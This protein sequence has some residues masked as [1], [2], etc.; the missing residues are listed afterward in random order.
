MEE[1]S[2]EEKVWVQKSQC[3]GF[4]FL[5][6]KFFEILKILKIKII[7]YLNKFYSFIDKTIIYFK[8]LYLSFKENLKI[9]YRDKYLKKDSN[10]NI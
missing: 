2:T 7:N 8:Y 5:K 3:E 6:N 10:L 9:F 4:Y 1:K